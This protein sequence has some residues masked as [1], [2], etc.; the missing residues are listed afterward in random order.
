MSDERRRYFRIESIVGLKTNKIARE[1]LEHKLENFWSDR[2]QFSLR[3]QFNH[4]LEQH[5]ADFRKIENK[6]PELARYLTVL[7]K[8]ID[9]VSALVQPDQNSAERNQQQVNISAQGIAYSS[10]E[11]V[12]VGDT[13]E[14]DLELTETGQKTLIFARVIEVEK[15]TSDDQGQYKIS[16][17]FE[18]IYEVD[19]EILAKYIHAK[20]LSNIGA[21]SSDINQA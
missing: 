19:R 10:D 6:M 20:Q 11:K 15:N 9:Q 8:Q 1:E 7:Q 12:V 4:Q 16:L 21:A 13:V 14:L 3:N 17:D 5:L 2:H 18:H